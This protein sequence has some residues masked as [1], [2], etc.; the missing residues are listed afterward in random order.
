MI[1]DENTK[2]YVGETEIEKVCQGQNIIYE[3]QQP[4]TKLQYIENDGNQ[5]I[6]T[7]IYL[8]NNVLRC[9]TKARGTSTAIVYSDGFILSGFYNDTY[10]I[11]DIYGDSERNRWAFYYG[12][13]LNVYTNL[14][15][16]KNID[17]ELDWTI[18]A[19]D[20]NVIVD[21][22][23]EQGQKSA[24]SYPNN[25]QLTMFARGTNSQYRFKGRIYYM[26][27]Y[28][29]AVL[30]RDFIPVLDENNVPCMY[31]KVSKTYFY[32]AGRGQFLYG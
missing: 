25:T 6:M 29:D 31:D 2:I 11:G 12:N 17:Y 21:N 5:Y 4:F 10:G 19:R 9:V 22:N 18:G 30:V 28:V 16:T 20:Y 15:Y 3:K 8:S 23:Q 7:G 26:K 14:Y 24:I 1:V 32:N 13:N 27:I